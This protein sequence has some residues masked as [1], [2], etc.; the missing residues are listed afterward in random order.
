MNNTKTFKSAYLSLFEHVCS[1]LGN[2][3][4][5]NKLHQN[6]EHLIKLMNTMLKNY[7]VVARKEKERIMIYGSKVMT[8]IT[9]SSI[10]SLLSS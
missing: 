5:I 7:S 1:F 2:G 10:N 8:D 6:D 3:W 9:S 4:R